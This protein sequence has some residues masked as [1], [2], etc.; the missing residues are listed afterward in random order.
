M[1][2]DSATGICPITH[3][4]VYSKHCLEC[5]ALLSINIKWA[6]QHRYVKSFTVECDPLTTNK[7]LLSG[8]GATKAN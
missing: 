7:K 6:P 3:Q 2:R 8:Q 1:K 4:L 5:Y